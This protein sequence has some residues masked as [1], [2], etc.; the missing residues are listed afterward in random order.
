MFSVPETDI[1]SVLDALKQV[2]H[3]QRF[4]SSVTALYARW[5]ELDPTNAWASATEEKDFLSEARRGVLLT[6]L[7]REPDIALEHLLDSPH[8][9]N[10]KILNEFLRDRVH[11][12]PHESALFVDKVAQAWPEA[13]KQLFPLVARAWSTF[14]PESTS[15]WVASHEHVKRRERLL[16]QIAQ[17]T[18]RNWGLRALTVA[19]RVE[20]PEKRKSTRLNTIRWIG[21]NFGSRL[22]SEKAAHDNNLR[23]GY[24]ADWSSRELRQFALGSM[25]NYSDDYPTLIK[26]ASSEEQ[27]Q[28]IHYGVIEGVGFS[29]PSLASGAVVALDNELLENDKNIQNKLQTFIKRWHEL[30]PDEA[31]EWLSQ[32]PNDAKTA[33][34]REI[35]PQP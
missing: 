33:V 35:I 11:H 26:Y 14:D 9:D 20:N 5:T 8:R 21:I 28:T 13:D 6:W 3:Q 34:M 2:T 12:S 4:E 29:Q 25:A 7:S 23:D 24:P 15:E 27:R 19:N 10:L 22:F 17:S 1:A 18:A 32:Q 31:Q 30:D 16:H